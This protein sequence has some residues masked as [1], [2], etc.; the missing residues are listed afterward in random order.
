MYA[1]K[2]GDRIRIYCQDGTP[3]FVFYSISTIAKTLAQSELTILERVLFKQVFQDCINQIP[4][5]A[6]LK[7]RVAMKLLEIELDKT[8]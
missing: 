1:K 4:I 2:D 3:F 7:K 6:R 5:P 8:I